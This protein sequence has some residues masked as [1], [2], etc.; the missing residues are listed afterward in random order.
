[1]EETKQSKKST[2]TS[3]A[4]ADLVF[5]EVPHGEGPKKHPSRSYDPRVVDYHSIRIND[6]WRITFIWSDS[7]PSK[8]AIVDYH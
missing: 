6:Q 2:T 8:V 3:V 5:P 1:M 7:G 4:V